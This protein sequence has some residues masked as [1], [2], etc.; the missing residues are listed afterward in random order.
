[1]CS[2]NTQVILDLLAMIALVWYPR[3]E[4][5]VSATAEA[6]SCSALPPAVSPTLCVRGLKLVWW[7]GG[8]HM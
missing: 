4:E 8:L 3:V 1:M 6:S 7:Q 2:A 5:L